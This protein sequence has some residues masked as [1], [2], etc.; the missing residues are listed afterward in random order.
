MRYDI[1]CIEKMFLCKDYSSIQ[2]ARKSLYHR[3][4]RLRRQ[5]Y[6]VECR[7]WDFGNISGEVVYTL[8]AAKPVERAGLEGD[9]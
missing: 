3:A 6:I 8:Q 7:R 1:T 5:G 4:R 2:A 9:W